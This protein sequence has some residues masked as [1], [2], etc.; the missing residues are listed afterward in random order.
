MTHYGT[1][2]AQG[3]EPFHLTRTARH[4]SPARS[5]TKQT[6]NP[7]FQGIG[8]EGAIHIVTGKLS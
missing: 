6:Y 3:A 2:V 5:E 7:I 4:Q 8:N 1:G